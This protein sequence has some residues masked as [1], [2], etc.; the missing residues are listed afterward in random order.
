MIDDFLE[1][2]CK[3]VINSVA[4]SASRLDFRKGIVQFQVVMPFPGGFFIE[5]EKLLHISETGDITSIKREDLQK[6]TVHATD[7]KECFW[8]VVAKASFL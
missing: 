8:S 1:A 3:T 5:P 2:N 6:V 4:Y 7:E